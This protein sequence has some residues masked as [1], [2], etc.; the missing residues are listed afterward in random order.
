MKEEQFIQCLDYLERNA[1]SYCVAGSTM[2]SVR[3][4]EVIENDQE[5]DIVVDEENYELCKNLAECKEVY[6]S[7]TG[8]GLLYIDIPHRITVTC[9][10]V[11]N[12][13]E[14]FNPTDDYFYIFEKGTIFPFSTL[15]FLQRN[16][17][18][19][20]L[21]EQYLLQQYGD[22]QTPKT[23]WHWTKSSYIRRLFMDNLGALF[24]PTGTKENPIPFDSL[25]IPWIYKEIYF[26]GVYIDILNQRKDMVIVDVGAN[27]GVV[28]QHM[29]PHAKTIYAIEP[30][31]EHFEALKKNKEFNHW[32]NVEI[33]NYAL[34]DKDGEMDMS[35][36]ASNRTCNS[37]VLNYGGT[38]VKVKTKRMDTFFKENNIEQVDFMKFDVEGAEDMIIRS[39]GFKSVADKIKAIEIEFHFP[40]WKQLADYLVSLGYTARVYQTSAIILLFT[41]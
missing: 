29:R 8:K 1:I 7:I 10:T 22:W 24:Y 41:R 15:P 4:N 36:N 17:S 6:K 14:L 23:Q 30:S 39:E 2:I 38:S 32:D 11:I 34:A 26:D 21:P 9:A 31:P 27:I 13:K 37:L 16:I 18:T 33:F 19:P 20:N 35:Q 3:R 5:F 28:T 12:D 25:Y 40:T